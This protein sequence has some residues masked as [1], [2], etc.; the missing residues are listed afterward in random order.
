[1][2]IKIAFGATNLCK[3]LSNNG[4]D[5]IGHYCQE[6]LQ[7]F[8]TLE[9]ISLSPYSFGCESASLSSHLLPRYPSYLAQSLFDNITNGSL[10]K[11]SSGYFHQFDLIHATDQLIPVGVDRPIIATVMDA[12]PISH[13][14]LT[15]SKI[16]RLKAFAWKKLTQSAD[17]IITIS[18]FSKQQIID[19]MHYPQDQISVISLGVD[20][21][22]FDT[23]SKQTITNVLFRFNL[24]N[25]FFLHLGTIQPRKNIVK[26]LS[27][28]SKLPHNLSKE[29]PLVL[30]GRYGWG[31]ASQLKAIN[32]AVKEG[33]C[34]WLNYVSDLEK[35]AL[36]Q[37]SMALVFAS[38]Y[39]GFGLPIIEAFAS[40]TPVITSANSSMIEVADNAAIL[41]DPNST[42][43]IKLALLQIIQGHQLMNNNIELGLKRAKELTWGLVALKTEQLY[44]AAI[45]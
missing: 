20:E 25:H 30:A 17:H 6:L 43:E 13:P 19:H 34:I 22:Y 38:L 9:G 33:R 1:M 41:I 42:D 2:S 32:Q 14:H 28:H 39:E 35:R 29:F 40:Q 31:D 3:G 5:G 4:I 16:A 7:H 8:S 12:I 18:E 45:R 11:N 27:A 36:L 24:P 21:R 26:I 44:K 37:T 10:S 15:P 23:L